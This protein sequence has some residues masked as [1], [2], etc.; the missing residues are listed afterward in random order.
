METDAGSRHYGGDH[1]LS[2][3]VLCHIFH[4]IHGK[5]VLYTSGGGCAQY[6]AVTGKT[7]K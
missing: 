3:Y 7:Y 4:V 2:G 6:K 1:S 5:Y